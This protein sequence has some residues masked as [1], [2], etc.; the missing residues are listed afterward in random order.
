[1]PHYLDEL[2]S[3]LQDSFDTGSR[4]VIEQDIEPLKLDV[5]KAIP[6]GLIIN[7]AVVN[8][9]KYAFPG[10]QNGIV[11]ISLKHNGP[12]HLALNISDNGIG[13]PP[14]IKV[15]KRGSLGFS[16]MHGLTRQLDGIFTI[17]SNKGLHITIRFSALNNQSYE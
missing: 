2:V 16:L 8:A 7:E 4:T 11:R 5:A 12:D 14:D 3:Y 9:I 1:M 6:L 13:L 17:E 15:S 10:R